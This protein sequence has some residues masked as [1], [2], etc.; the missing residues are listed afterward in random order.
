MVVTTPTSVKSF[1]LKL[2]ELLHK[3]D[4]SR[5]HKAEEREDEG[6]A[7][8]GIR[9]VLRLDVARVLCNW[10]SS[11]EYAEALFFA[12]RFLALAMSSHGTMAG[13]WRAGFCNS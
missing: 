11:S 5:L 2:V 7:A 10:C 12:C 6:G 1:M 3:L 4:I 8:G 13:A 9:C